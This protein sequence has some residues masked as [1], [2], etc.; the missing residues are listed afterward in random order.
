MATNVTI[1]NPAS[2]TVKISQNKSS[3]TLSVTPAD[4]LQNLQSVTTL[5]NTTSLPISLTNTTTSV[6]NTTGSLIVSG[7]VGIKGNVYADAIYDNGTRIITFA[8]AA[9]AQA[10]TDVTSITVTGG[11]F[12]N[13]N[14][15]P[16]VTLLAN[17]RVSSI[18][19][20][21]ISFPPEAD[22]LQTVTTRGSTTAN[23]INITN[24]TASTSNSTGALIVSGG[25]GITG[26][27]YASSI[28]VD[29]ITTTSIPL[30]LN[31]IS[32][33]FDGYKNVF[34]LTVDQTPISNTY[35]TDSKNLEV[36]V[37]GKRLS[38]YVKQNTFP[39]LT[40]YDSF[41]G[42]RVVPT[43]NSANLIIYN[44][45]DPGDTAFLTIINSSL[46]IQTRKYPYSA[47]TIALGD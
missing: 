40:P 39:W 18:V 7:G 24:T 45:P 35:I 4:I 41:N 6:S 43:T 31:D 36:V 5:G 28:Y 22:T 34:A 15:I 23:A 21:A 44:A 26:N 12:G 8:N 32:N 19:N 9:F 42:F 25:I 17:G 29:K 16:I 2:T 13:A 27:V 10:N 47:T 3:A 37:S 1:T 46:T 33:Q 30:V 38:P 14:T 11:V 20:T